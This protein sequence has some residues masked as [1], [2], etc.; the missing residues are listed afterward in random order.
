MDAINL[1]TQISPDLLPKSRGLSPGVGILLGGRHQ[2]VAVP[3]PTSGGGDPAEVRAT[4]PRLG[5][6]VGAG[7]AHPFGFL[8]SSG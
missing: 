2:E 6:K 3:P 4:R 7:K 5:Q 1:H 8:N